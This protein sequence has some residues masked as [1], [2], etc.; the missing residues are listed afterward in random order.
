MPLLYESYKFVLGQGMVSPPQRI[1]KLRIDKK[2][3]FG[4]WDLSAPKIKF[5]IPFLWQGLG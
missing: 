5:K 1:L 3:R 4:K 2:E